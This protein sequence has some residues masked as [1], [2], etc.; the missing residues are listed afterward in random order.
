MDKRLSS[1]V[2]NMK[3]RFRDWTESRDETSYSRQNILLSNTTSGVVNNLIGGNFFTGFLLLMNADDGFMGIVTMASYLGNLLQV[4]SPLVIERF[5]SRKLLLTI[6]RAIIYLFNIVVISLIPFVPSTNKLKLMLILCVVLFINVINALSAPGFAIWHI[7]SIPDKV[8]ANF[9][10]IFTT[11]N[12]I[13]VYTVILASSAIVDRFKE[14]GNELQG[15]LVLRGIALFLCLVDL[16]FLF[17][18]KEY[19]YQPSDTKVNLVNTLLNPFKEKKYLITVL[20]ACLW[21]FSANI[22]G[23]YYTVYMLKDMKVSYSFLN[24]INMVNIPALIFLTP[25]WRKRINSTSWFKTLYFSMGLFLLN[26]IGL[27]FVTRDL[28]FLYPISV[29]FSIMITPGINLVF[30]NVPYINIPEK[31]QTNYIGFYSTMNYL[32]ALLGVLTGKEFIKNTEGIDISLLGIGMQ[33]KQ[34]ILLLT[35]AVMFISVIL[36]RTLHKKSE[37]NSSMTSNY[38]LTACNTEKK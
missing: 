22:P 21:N 1:I 17:K 26:Y 24:I 8:R 28:L 4:L 2:T 31:N 29:I 34:Y 35:A 30:A 6:S 12:G 16:F 38:S 3:S 20:I 14:S 37:N 32:A 33:N 18:I 36:I 9:F 19:P 27:A 5:S 10:A 7:K 13:I 11:V 25:L 15:L 23:P